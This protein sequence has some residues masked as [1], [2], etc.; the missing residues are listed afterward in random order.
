[1]TIITS[2]TA[3]LKLQGLG[4]TNPSTGALFDETLTIGNRTATCYV[5]VRE[6]DPEP[7]VGPFYFAYDMVSGTQYGYAPATTSSPAII[8]TNPNLSVNSSSTAGYTQDFGWTSWSSEA[9]RT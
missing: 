9:A 6:N 4:D 1:M 7:G 5:K 2:G 3:D 8:D